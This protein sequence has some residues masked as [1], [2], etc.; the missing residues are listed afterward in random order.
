M[1]VKVI[2][3]EKRLAEINLTK[4]KLKQ[5]ILTSLASCNTF[6]CNITV[7]LVVYEPSMLSVAMTFSIATFNITVM[8]KKVWNIATRKNT[9]EGLILH[10]KFFI[11]KRA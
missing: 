8:K 11:H 2:N 10:L 9:I 7:R 1:G 5:Q 3:S 4:R 6:H